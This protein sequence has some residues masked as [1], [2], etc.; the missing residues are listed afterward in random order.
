MAQIVAPLTDMPVTGA[1]RRRDVPTGR[2][3]PLARPATLPRSALDQPARLTLYACPKAFL[4]AL[5]PKPY[6]PR[7]YPAPARKRPEQHRSADILMQLVVFNTRVMLS[8]MWI[9]VQ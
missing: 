4:N 8:G 3:A 7:P 1:V 6:E 2:R 9:L 5:Y